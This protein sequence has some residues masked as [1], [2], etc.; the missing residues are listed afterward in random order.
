MCGRIFKLTPAG[1]RD[2]ER[3]GR[4]DW[5]WRE[6]RAGVMGRGRG[7]GEGG[8]D[9]AVGRRRMGFDIRDP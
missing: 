1:V 5:A 2:G 3:E 4:L 8:V 6:A 9:G 7:R